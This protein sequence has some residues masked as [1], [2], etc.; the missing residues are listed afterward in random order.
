VVR[1]D[2][3]P[4]SGVV[5]VVYFLATAVVTLMVVVSAIVA[6]YDEPN[7]GTV[8]EFGFG[9]QETT[10]DNSQE[11]YRRNVSLILSITSA[12]IFATSILGLGS[13]FNPLRAGLLL[14]GL[15]VYLTAIGFW[16]SSTDQWIGFVMTALNFAVLAGGFLYLE[17][18]IPL[19]PSTPVRR[20]DIPPGGASSQP[21]GAPPPVP[22]PVPPPP[23]PP[24]FSPPPRTMPPDEPTVPSPEAGRPS[25]D[26]QLS[27]PLG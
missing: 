21:S 5:R 23:P 6:F 18:G 20:L 11:N 10:S 15:L 17:E 12:G 7:E 9:F 13:R 27:G 25:P 3:P 26:D 2:D 1:R 22:P 19:G 8:D 4:L 14:G 16:A 24:A